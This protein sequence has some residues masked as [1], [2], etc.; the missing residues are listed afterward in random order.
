METRLKLAVA[1]FWIERNGVLEGFFE[2]WG[3]DF[4]R[5][6][7]IVFW[8]RFGLLFKV[9][10]VRILEKIRAAV[11]GEISPC[12]GRDLGCCLGWNH[13]MFWKKFRLLFGVKSVCILEEIWVV[14]QRWNHIVFWKRF[15][16][17]FEMKSVCI[18]EEI[19]A[20]VWGE[21][22]PYF[23]RDLGC[24][25]GWYQSVFWKIFGLLFGVKSVCV[26]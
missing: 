5:W 26:L 19:W 25:S 16:L 1:S 22:S 6:N 21:I 7:Q 18:L 11:R 3:C 10:L 2:R 24:C 13:I 23:G 17:L 8:K 12:F 14:V 4:Q 20:V 15:G 9:K